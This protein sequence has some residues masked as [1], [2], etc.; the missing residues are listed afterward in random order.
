MRYYLLLLLTKLLRY[1][2][3]YRHI[4]CIEVYRRQ[5]RNYICIHAVLWYCTEVTGQG[6]MLVV[7]G[8]IH[9]LGKMEWTYCSMFS[10]MFEVWLHNSSYMNGH[11]VLS[12]MNCPSAYKNLG[13]VHC[14]FMILVGPLFLKPSVNRNICQNTITKL[15]S[16]LEHE[17]YCWV[18]QDGF[19][20]CS[21]KSTCL[22]KLQD[23]C[24][25]TCGLKDLLIGLL[26]FLFLDLFKERL[27]KKQVPHI[28]RR[29]WKHWGS[30]R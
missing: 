4:H 19:G 3:F 17:C 6:A 26:Q 5:Q 15:I 23:D 1:C 28:Q 9:S 7:G 11:K 18:Q 8:F 14:V 24:F 25:Y 21:L 27:F 2:A 22:E 12:F 10:L 20:C 16:L 29:S 30:E 13:I